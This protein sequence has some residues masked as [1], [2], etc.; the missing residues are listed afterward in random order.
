MF[1]VLRS[2]RKIIHC[3]VG[4]WCVDLS[5]AF[6]FGVAAREEGRKPWGRS[7]EEAGVT[8]RTLKLLRH[9]VW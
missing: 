1:L 9:G 4:L 5:V 8:S 6:W 2:E 7:E 3:C